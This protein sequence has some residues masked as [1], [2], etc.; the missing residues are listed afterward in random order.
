M[1]ALP[2]PDKYASGPLVGKTEAIVEQIGEVL[3]GFERQRH[4]EKTIADLRTCLDADAFQAAR[5]D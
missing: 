3:I 1:K 2:S 5:A 4:E